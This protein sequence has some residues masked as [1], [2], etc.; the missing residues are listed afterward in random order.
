MN[1]DNEI[2]RLTNDWYKYVSFDHHKD[3]DCHWHID[4][5][6]SYGQEPQYCVYHHGYIAD[7]NESYYPD[8]QSAKRGLLSLLY[9]IIKDEKKW[10]KLALKEGIEKWDECQIKKAEY[11]SKIYLPK[12]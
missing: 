11:I 9:E 3:S 4:M 8:Y 6:W 2:L 12:R 7:K 1:I 5:V 10:S